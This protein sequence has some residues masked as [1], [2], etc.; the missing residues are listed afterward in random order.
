MN[1]VLGNKVYRNKV[2]RRALYMFHGIAEKQNK[3]E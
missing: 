2:L 3:E 1:K